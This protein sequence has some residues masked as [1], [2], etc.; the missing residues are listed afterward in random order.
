MTIKCITD[1]AEL[2]AFCAKVADLDYITVDT[3]FLREK[4]YYPK[5]CL[6][7]V[8]GQENQAI[9]DPLADGIDLSAFYE[10][11]NKEDLVK[12]FHACR[13]DLE[14]FYQK[15]GKVPSPVFDTQVAA[16]VTGHGDQ[17][18]YETLVNR[19]LNRR[20]DKSARFTD[21]SMRPL[22]QK[23]LAYALSDVTHLCDIY[24][25][26]KAELDRSDR[27]SWLEEEMVS[28]TQLS[29]FEIDP[30]ESWRK[31]KSR[32]T[33]PRFLAVLREVA[34]WRELEAQQRDVPKNR[35]VRDEALLDIAGSKPRNAKEL[36]KIR[37]VS[38][39]FAEGKLGNGLLTAVSQAM[40]LPE[41]ELPRVPKKER[42]PDGIGPLSDLLK[43]LL[44]KQSEEHQ[45]AS[46]L[47][48]NASD[49]E[50]IAGQKKPDVPAMHGWRYEL[51]GRQAEDL[52]AGRLALA[53]KGNNIKIIELG[54][55]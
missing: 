37:G 51:F 19:I 38:D 21:W 7:Q 23:Q 44:K 36:A 24:E 35:I 47:I 42:L 2:A 43:V 46:R 40:A 6:I 49:L 17:V 45:V 39:G 28:T 30:K 50:L 13:Q 1:T 48:A 15:T 26:F 4:T 18:G 10:L 34:A 31:I 3:E 27:H 5:L 8:A 11:L 32:G 33:E 55:E 12:V 20:L 25:L 14:I 16:M 29:N 22:S 52:K 9:I 54:E 41:S 53:A